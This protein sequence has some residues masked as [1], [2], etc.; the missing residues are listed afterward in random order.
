MADYN[1]IG[2]LI[3]RDKKILMC[4]KDNTTSKLIMPGGCLEQGEAPLQ[5]LQR[6]LREELGEVSL[7]NLIYLG[8]Y[9]DKAAV[10]DPKVHKTLEMEL[11]QGELTGSPSPHS[12]IKELVWY[13]KEDDRS[14]LTPIMLNKILPDLIKRR[15]LPWE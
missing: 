4:R 14:F 8:T 2:V 15:I 9:A 3:L 5:C 11:Y 10:D 6:E 13:G 12:E 7:S 1:K